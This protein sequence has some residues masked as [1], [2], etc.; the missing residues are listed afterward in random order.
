MPS[1]LHKVTAL[2]TRQGENGPELLVFQHPSAGIQLP[3]GTV[4]ADEPIE[5]AL[6]REVEEE[7]GLSRVRI[8]GLLGV[9]RRNLQDG[10]RL[11]LQ[12]TYP[13]V[14]PVE[15]TLNLG[16]WLTRGSWVRQV[17]QEGAFAEVVYE[18][19]DL[20][21]DPPRLTC[22]F[23]GWLP[24]DL[25]TDRLER[26]F[27]HLTLTAPTPE[28]WDQPSD[29]GRIYRLFWTLLVPRPRLVTGQDEWLDLVYEPLIA[30]VQNSFA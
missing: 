26:H 15:G 3:A 19:H 25:L 24:A 7:T 29:G 2:I 23:S 27:F 16:F 5:A 12:Y 4:E 6:L 17:G 10:W 1:T 22:R 8:V 14:G 13:L 9:D 20:N 11:V 18:E 28:I 21:V 30:S